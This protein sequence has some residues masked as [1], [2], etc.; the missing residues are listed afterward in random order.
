ME[1]PGC[2]A[3]APSRGVAMTA[4]LASYVADLDLPGEPGVSTRAVRAVLRMMAKIADN[5]GQFRYGLRGSKLASLTE[6]SLSVVRR[7]QRY[8]VEHG[9]LERVQVGGGRASTRWRILIHKLR[10]DHETRHSSTSNQTQQ[11][12][13]P[14]TALEHTPKFFPHMHQS[15]AGERS[16]TPPLPVIKTCEHGDETGLLR[17]GLPRCPLCRRHAR[18]ATRGSR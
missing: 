8:L 5:A 1:A 2:H 16:P 12:C 7:A 18:T 15:A 6:Y 11:P 17:S 14:D 4:A 9:F 13:S 10:P 3:R